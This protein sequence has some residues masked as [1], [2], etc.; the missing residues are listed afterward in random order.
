M[1][2]IWIFVFVSG[3]LHGLVVLLFW[4]MGGSTLKTPEVS[5]AMD[6]MEVS[7]GYQESPAE[8]EETNEKRVTSHHVSRRPHL[9]AVETPEKLSQTSPNF[10]SAAAPLPAKEGAESDGKILTEYIQVIVRTVAA[11]RNYPTLAIDRGIEG[12]VVVAVTI[13]GDGTIS[14]TVIKT[15]SP[16]DLLNNAALGIFHRIQKFPPL[17][18]MMSAPVVLDVPIQYIINRK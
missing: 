2:G 17:P 1:R 6:L 13:Q 8:L 4:N 14:Q 12:R 18:P 5:V 11:H 16:F 7:A 15:A 9:H 3:V 10:A